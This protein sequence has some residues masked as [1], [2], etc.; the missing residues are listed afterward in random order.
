MV[1][2]VIAACQKRKSDEDYLLHTFENACSTFGGQNISISEIVL[3]ELN[4]QF[5]FT[6]TLQKTTVVTRDCRTSN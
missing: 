3:K 2:Y 1:T 5:V 6:K 4:V